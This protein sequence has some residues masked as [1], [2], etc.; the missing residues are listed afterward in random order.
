MKKLLNTLYVLT[1][2]S[3]L[4]VRNQTVGIKLGGEEKY[5][6]PAGNLDSIVCFGVNTVSTPFMGFCAENGIALSFLSPQGRFLGRVQGGVNGN[7]LLRQ[8]QYHLLDDDS[9]RLETVKNI[10]LCKLR[11]SREVL[12]R[13]GRNQ[14]DDSASAAL[15]AAAKSIAAVAQ[16]LTL[17]ESLDS[18]RGLEGVAAAQYF[19]CFDTMLYASPLK[20]KERSRR[21][22]KN[23]V[24][25]VL[26]FV[27]TILG[28]EI[29][30]ALE[31]VGLDPAAGIMYSLRPGRN[32]FALDLLEELRA[33]LCDRFVI[34]L[35]N[36]HRLDEKDFDSDGE[37]VYLNDK[38]RRTVL[39]AWQQRKQET[40]LHPF[41]NEKLQIGIIPHSQAMLYARYLR[42][43]LD[44]YPPYVWR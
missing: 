43:D 28:N 27:Y 38:G 44:I 16:D 23:E 36:Q 7:V 29:T 14:K 39:T 34:S 30:A 8:A 4:Y 22:P 11:N 25:A 24:N 26:S 17:A 3:Y 9:R 31:A 32:S 20:F 6:V 18:L 2:E 15:T 13:S 5:S 37:G 19:A 42:G 10:L 35:F 41:L 12:L 33:P 21:P 1:P 40:V